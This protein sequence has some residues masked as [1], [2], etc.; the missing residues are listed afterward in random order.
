MST[1]VLVAGVGNIFQGDDGFG[2][3]VAQQLAQ[4]ALPAGV[5]VLDIGIRGLH[6]AYDLLEPVDLLI[7]VDAAARG[8]APGTLTVIEPDADAAPAWADAHSFSVPA[9]F[10]S[11]RALGGVV[12][13]T[14]VVGCEP[15]DLGERLGL[16]PPVE[17]AVATAVALVS[18]LINEE[19][20]A[21][22]Q[23]TC[24]VP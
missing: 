7:V 11:L 14:L 18:R 5:R 16:S 1:R 8:E 13:R 17:G 2:V 9:V 21:V 24:A 4:S 15:E 3:A 23:I 22:D 19:V 12:P 20:G 10:A 6:L